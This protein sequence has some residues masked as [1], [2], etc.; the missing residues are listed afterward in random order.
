MFDY[1]WPESEFEKKTIVFIVIF[2]ENSKNFVIF[3]ESTNK[4]GEFLES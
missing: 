3:T 2:L 4:F 1:K